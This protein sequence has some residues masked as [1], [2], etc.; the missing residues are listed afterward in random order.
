MS[1]QVLVIALC[2]SEFSAWLRPGVD[3]AH[4]RPDERPYLYQ[5]RL[6]FAQQMATFAPFLFNNYLF[7]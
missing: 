6:D 4:N 1:T 7:P 2:T 3:L 5:V